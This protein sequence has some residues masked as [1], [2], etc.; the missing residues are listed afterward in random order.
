MSTLNESSVRQARRPVLPSLNL[1]SGIAGS[2][3]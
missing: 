2:V 1:S 3:L